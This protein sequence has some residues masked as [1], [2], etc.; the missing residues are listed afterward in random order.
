MELLVENLV[1]IDDDGLVCTVKLDLQRRLQLVFFRDPKYLSKLSVFVEI[2]LGFNL[3][4]F[5]TI[6]NDAP[7]SG[8]HNKE[9][10][11]CIAFQYCTSSILKLSLYG[12]LL[13]AVSKCEAAS[14]G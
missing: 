4:Y 10:H 3:A 14:H 13:Y 9:L 5:I 7:L 6:N 2:N 12:A 11:N 8:P 1:K